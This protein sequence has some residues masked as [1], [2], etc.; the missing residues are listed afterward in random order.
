LNDLKLGSFR[1]CEK[2]DFPA[3][4]S[5]RTATFP[6][7]LENCFNFEEKVLTLVRHYGI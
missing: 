5:L 1:G 6:K 2:I 7:L 3:P 4:S